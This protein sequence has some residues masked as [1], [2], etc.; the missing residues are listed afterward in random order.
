MKAEGGWAC[1]C[2]ETIGSAEVGGTAGLM[3]G[4]KWLYLAWHA[5]CVIVAV[6]FR[7][8]GDNPEVMQEEGWRGLSSPL[9]V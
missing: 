9:R 3:P 1:D 2:D 7:K 8:L 4:E 6:C 5:D